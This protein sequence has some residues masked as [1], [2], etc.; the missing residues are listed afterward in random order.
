MEKKTQWQTGPNG[1]RVELGTL[2][3]EGREFTNMGAVITET[4]AA[5]YLSSDMKAIHS[6]EG[7]VIGSARVV[8]SWPMPRS[9]QSDRQYQVVA[10]ID[11]RTYT[12]R[13][14]GAGMLWRGRLK[15]S[16]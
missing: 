12:G 7:E 11:G 8:S 16:K 5:G 3:H 1:E 10:T 15:R 4:H 13:T 6:W 2:T 9:W 14:M